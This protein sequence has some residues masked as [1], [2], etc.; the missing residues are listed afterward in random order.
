[1]LLL[2][3]QSRTV[4]LGGYMVDVFKINIPLPSESWQFHPSATQKGLTYMLTSLV[5]ESLSS[6]REGQ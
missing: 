3:I 4:T 2:G 5:L 6:N 1:M